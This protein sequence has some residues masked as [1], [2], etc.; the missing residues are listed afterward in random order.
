MPGASTAVEP[1]SRDGGIRVPTIR[2][3]IPRSGEPRH[4]GSLAIG[5]WTIPCVI[6]SGGLAPAGAKR[7]GDKR[8][9]IGVFPLRYG[10]YDPVN[11][12][13][14]EGGAAFPFVPMRDSMIWEEDA[15]SPHY[16]R[17]LIA[18]EGA[19]PDERLTRRRA[20]G[21]F[22]VVV[23]IGYND[24]T[25]EPFRGSAIFIHAARPDG[26]GTAGCVAVQRGHLEE[27]ARRLEPGMMID[28]GYEADGAGAM[29]D[30]REAGPLET[31]SFKGLRPGPRLIVTGAV[32][33]NEPCGPA[34]IR[35]AIA[36][37]RA[38]GLRIER[39]QVTF[40]PVVNLKAYLGNKRN[41]DR[42][43]NRDLREATIPRDN[44]DRIANVLCPLLR[45]HDVLLD[46]HSFR[47]AGEP[48]VFLGPRDN[49][50]GIEPFA[51]A[52][53][54]AALASIL[55]PELVMHGWLDTHV[56]G[57]ARKRS[58]AEGPLSLGVGTTEYMRF[59]GGYGV[60]LECGRHDDPQA[61]DVAYRAILNAL[62]HL[63]L[64]AAPEPARAARRAIELVDVALAGS[65][66]DRLERPWRTGDPVRAG[67]VIAR[68][69]G[70]EP[71]TAPR[72]GFVVFPDARPTAG[73][74]LFY[75]GVASARLEG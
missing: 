24:A 41:G 6:G 15:A 60:T 38:G 2:V 48:F 56:K 19:R 18:D 40:V 52:A 42:N 67:E 9:P 51:H 68:R 65:A 45:G 5:D 43:L 16:N 57:V 27:L 47:S 63:K 44:E 58:S 35:R 20:E 22:D 7:E 11:C 3:R 28:I 70:G 64:I 59:A 1:E 4:H 17:L 13:S 37:C 74:E 66:E 32:H 54:E 34:A 30:A 26:S 10:F 73:E 8:T 23:P 12:P 46:L 36:G 75:F 29:S 21:L 61:E 50:D 25:A 14:L 69:A 62:A 31:V 55:G 33:G 53:A 49:D 71:L 39:G 72:D